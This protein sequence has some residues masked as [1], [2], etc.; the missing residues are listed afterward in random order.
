MNSKGSEMV[1]LDTELG[2]FGFAL[3]YDMRFPELFRLLALGGAQVV[4]VPA[5]FTKPTGEAHWHTLLRARAIEN[6]VY[7]VAP[8]QTGEKPR[9]TAYGHSMV[10]DPWGRIIAEIDQ[11]EGLIVAEIDPAMSPKIQNE[12]GSLK[13]RRTDL[14]S[15]TKL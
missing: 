8:A 6:G 2:K 9:F 4:F 3:C 14:Y 7:I 1:L 11:G 13:N 5:N 10:I 12:V 15:L